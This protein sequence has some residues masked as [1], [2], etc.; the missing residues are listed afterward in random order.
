MSKR[1]LEQ[2]AQEHRGCLEPCL[3]KGQLEVSRILGKPSIASASSYLLGSERMIKTQEALVDLHNLKNIA[4]SKDLR[5]SGGSCDF[6]N[7]L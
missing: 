1:K 3:D 5:T 7:L 2:P 4:D 6:H